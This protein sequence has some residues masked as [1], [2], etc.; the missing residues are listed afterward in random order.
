MRISSSINE[1]EIDT[2]CEEIRGGQIACKACGDAKSMQYP[3]GFGE[4]TGKYLRFKKCSCNDAED[5]EI[6]TERLMA[7]RLQRIKSLQL[8]SLMGQQFFSA[9]FENI[10]LGI[11]PAIDTAARR[12]ATYAEISGIAYEKGLGAYI[13][14]DVGVGKTYLMSC[15]ANALIDK[16]LPVIFTSFIEISRKVRSTFGSQGAEHSEG[17]LMGQIANAD[18]L[19]LDDIGSESLTPWMRQLV[20]EVLDSRLRAQKPTL[21]SSNYAIPELAGRGYEKRCVDRIMMLST[22]VMQIKGPNLRMKKAQ[23]KESWF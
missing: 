17:E 8:E 11:S 23:E 21:F 9:R 14:G 6:E 4:L 13:Y 3:E 20:Y 15:C 22:E 12:L 18:F 7:D 10:S 5:R 1:F 19:F 16:L 2:E